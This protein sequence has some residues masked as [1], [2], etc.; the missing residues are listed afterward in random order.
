MFFSPSL[1]NNINYNMVTRLFIICNSLPPMSSHFLEKIL[2]T[3][4]TKSLTLSPCG[5]DIIYGRTL[6]DVMENVWKYLFC[7]VRTANNG[8]NLSFHS[9]THEISTLWKTGFGRTTFFCS[10]STDLNH[11]QPS[12]NVVKLFRENCTIFAIDENGRK[13]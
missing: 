13:S 5:Y 6:Y 7:V 1:S 8:G 4:V 9:T 10:I 2:Y 3:I 12:S 11:F